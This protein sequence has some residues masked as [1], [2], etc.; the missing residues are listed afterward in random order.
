MKIKTVAAVAVSG[1]LA[2]ST[3][4]AA[5]GSCGSHDDKSCGS[6]KKSTCGSEMKEACGAKGACGSAKKSACGSEMKKACGM[7]GAC[8]GMKE[9]K[10]HKHGEKMH[11]HHA[12]EATINTDGLKALISAGTDVVVLDARSGK[13]DDGRRIPGAAALNDGSS[14]EEIAQVVSAKD[15]LIVTY[16]SNVKCPA[17]SKLAKHLR[18]LG[19]EN[20]VEY[21]QGIQGWSEAGN[22]VEQAGE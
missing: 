16:C 3:V 6:A 14:A 9:G 7:K 5:C 13:Y 17:S 1:I 15:Q 12:A 2:A 18:Q 4:Y 21:P 8:G 10:H 11:R 20:V 19:Y 22:D